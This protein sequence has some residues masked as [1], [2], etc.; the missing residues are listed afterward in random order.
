MPQ[1]QCLARVVHSGADVS[2]VGSDEGK[3]ESA[4]HDGQ[5]VVQEEGE[6]GVELLHDLGRLPVSA[7][8]VGGQLGHEREGVVV[9]LVGEAVSPRGTQSSRRG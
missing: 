4:V 1:R 9:E 6:G 7:H 8:D 2:H 5:E 3:C